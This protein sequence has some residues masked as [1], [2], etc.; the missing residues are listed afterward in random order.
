[1]ADFFCFDC[2]QFTMKIMQGQ[3]IKS[4]Y[5]LDVHPKKKKDQEEEDLYLLD[6]I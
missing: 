5:N 3:P 4:L 6:E 2:P 1:M